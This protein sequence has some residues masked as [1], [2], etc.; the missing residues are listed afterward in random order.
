MKIYKGFEKAKNGT[1]IP[2]FLSGRTME[3]RYNPQRDAQTLLDSIEEGFSFFLVL[4]IGSGLFLKLL[5][6]KYPQAKILALELYSEDL[7]FLKTGETIQELL[8]K[9]SV[10]FCTLESLE[11]TLIKNYIPSKYGNLK[12]IEQRAWI[13]ENQT[14]VQSINSV[15]QKTLGIISADFSVQAHFGKLWTSNIMNNARLA[16]ELSEKYSISLSKAELTKTA[17][18]VAAGPSLDQTCELLK[19][20][21]KYFII[22]TDTAGTALIRKGIIPDVIISIDGQSVSYNHFM[23][24]AARYEKEPLY[25]FDLCA[26]FSAVKHVAASQ[27]RLCFFCSGHPLSSAINISCGSP[28]PV[29]FSGAGT[30]TITALDFAIQAGFK[31]LII[32]GADFSYQNGKAYTAGTYLDTL[33][34]KNSSR[35]SET[36]QTFTKLMFRT[37]LKSVTLN[38]KTTDILEAYKYSLE[39]YLEDKRINFTKKDDIYQLEN[40]SPSVKLK[41]PSA[42]FT[43]KPF[44]NKLKASTPEDAEQ[45]LLPYLAW[46]RNN[47]R[48]KNKAY[49]ELLKLALDC[50][51]SYNICYEK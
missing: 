25:A 36:E 14:S 5:S 20:Q 33:Y 27:K 26:N 10:K 19:Q 45:L 28:L 16:E 4:G 38:I 23:K 2:V 46:L 39:K 31:N 49:N 13:N 22:A 12:I 32:L 34:N 3:S 9:D 11:K 37:E 6:E 44:M 8:K 15:L 30:V 48:Y 18:I 40:L 7:D 50:I 35:L 29:L 24:A 21:N 43:L 17:A 1:K 51:V 47:P 41:N 42:A